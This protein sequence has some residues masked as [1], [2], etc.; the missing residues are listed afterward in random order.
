MI[1]RKIP[2]ETIQASRPHCKM[3]G[4]ALAQGVES[5]Q[6]SSCSICTSWRKGREAFGCVRLAAAFG[7]FNAL[8]SGSKLPHSKR[9]AP[10]CAV[11]YIWH[12]QFCEKSRQIQ[13]PGRCASACCMDAERS[14]IGPPPLVTACWFRVCAADRRRV[15][16]SFRR[17]N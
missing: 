7:R 1:N 2:A 11:E 9:F 15:Y 12:A 14:R 16:A 6:R 3:H 17:S 10:T 4:R 13:H 8:E 5:R